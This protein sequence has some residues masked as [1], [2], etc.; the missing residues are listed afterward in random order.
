MMVFWT[1][2]GVAALV[3][4]FAILI[5][6]KAWKSGGELKGKDRRN[7]YILTVLLLVAIFSMVG[8]TL[9]H[10]TLV[11]GHPIDFSEF[12]FMPSWI[13]ILVPIWIVASSKK[14]KKPTKQEQKL[15]M[16]AI[17]IGVIALIAGVLAFLI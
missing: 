12:W 5:G 4:I 17:L 7:A 15:I 10:E 3:V 11:T 1:I 13:A 2:L 14:K 16:A 6:W 8:L 9:Y